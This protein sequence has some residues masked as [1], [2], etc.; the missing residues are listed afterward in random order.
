M[1]GD[2]DGKT[3]KRNGDIV[4]RKIA[5]E[6]F[7]VPIRGKIA[8]MQRIF[9]LNPVAEYIWQEIDQQSLDEIRK[10]ITVRFDVEE[11]TAGTDL[12][13]FIADL[14]EAALIRE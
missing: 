5:G 6:L 7:L 1:N 9:T 4:T 10:G 2:M 8:D 12:C 11:E 3:Y 14:L 13:E